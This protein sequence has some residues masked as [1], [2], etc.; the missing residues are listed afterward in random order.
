M[1][2]KR[3]RRNWWNK[4]KY[5][6][7]ED[8]TGNGCK[9]HGVVYTLRGFTEIKTQ[10]WK[11]DTGFSSGKVTAETA[12][13]VGLAL[14]KALL[15][16]QGPYVIPVRCPCAHCST[17]GTVGPQCLL[18]MTDY[19]HWPQ[20]SVFKCEYFGK[21][22]SMLLSGAVFKRKFQVTST[23]GL[24]GLYWPRRGEWL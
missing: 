24:S 18:K 23:L 16:S 12:G 17:H 19:I 15:D 11:V 21:L 8:K 4:M 1:K 7:M 2:P 20:I 6:A 22:Y 9:D 13:R 14:F 10:G 3:L 5:R